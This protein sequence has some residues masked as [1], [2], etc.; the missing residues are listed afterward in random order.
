MDTISHTLSIGTPNQG[1]DLFCN[2]SIDGTHLFRM[3][4]ESFVG[5]FLRDIH[6]MMHGGRTK[7][8][9]SPI[10]QYIPDYSITSIRIH[11]GAVELYRYSLSN[12]FNSGSQSPNP[13]GVEPVWVHIWGCQS[14]PQLNGTWE[15]EGTHSNGNYVR[16]KDAPT[17]ID[18]TSYVAD[19]ATV[20]AKSYQS[21]GVTQRYCAP[22]RKLYPTLGTGNRPVSV[23]DVGLENVVDALLSRGAVSVSG[24]I[25]DQ[26]KSIFT[27]SA[28][29]TNAS[30]Q[31]ISIQE[32]GLMTYLNTDR[33]AGCNIGNLYARDIL[34]SAI[35]LPDA[36]TLT[37][38]YECKF[39]LE[40]FNQ[41]T[42][43]NG[44]NGGLLAEFANAV[45][46]QAVNTTNSSWARILM[47]SLGGGTSMCSLEEVASDNDQGWKLGLRLGQSN[48]FVSMTDT[49]LS[50]DANQDTPYNIGGI[51]HGSG[52]GQLIHHGMY[53]D[54]NVTIDEANNEAYF[55]ISRV[56]ENRG[57]TDITIKE[58]GL[59]TKKDNTSNRFQSKLVARKA[60]APADQFTIM[61]GQ[62]RKVNYKMK[63]TV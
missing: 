1:M 47:A 43:L 48:K 56:F 41:N 6:G 58:I 10:S 15:V 2:V 34:Q 16:L 23:S 24:V 3:H 14:V 5:N 9:I 26:E 19:D 50:P 36:K 51:T 39:E 33:S 44:T 37:L 32:M 63:L 4:C 22:I 53:I 61:A 18:P 8:L 13:N 12:I 60:L 30:G 27:I 29:F 42:N 7:R 54:D 46:T 17:T 31:D 20:I 11:E 35:N 21:I 45:R 38:D 55:N 52:D 28:P 49:A 40:N 62:M 57:T 25:T 59:Y